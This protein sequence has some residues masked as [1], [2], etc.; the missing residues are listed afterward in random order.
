MGGENKGQLP[1]VVIGA[2]FSGLA[3]AAALADAGV[4]VHV[5]E[6]NAGIGGRARVRQSGGFT[7]DMGPSWYWMP[8][9]FER[10]YRR[11]GHTTSDFYDLVQLDPGFRM[12]FDE[13]EY[14][15]IP[16]D[17]EELCEL[18]ERTEIGAAGKLRRFIADAGYKYEVGVNNL[19]YKPARSIFEF[20]SIQM[21]RDV[22]KLQVF[23][24]FSSYIRRYFTHPRLLSLLEFPVLF[25][26]A[27]PKDTPALYSLMNYAGLRQGTWYPMGGFGRVVDAFAAIARERGAE[28]STSE[29]V[30]SLEVATG[31]IERV[32]TTSRSVKVGSVIGAADYHH[33]EQALLKPEYRTYSTQ[34]WEKKT[35]APS[36]LIYYIGTNKKIN[37]LQHHNLFFDADLNRH[38]E[39]IYRTKTWPENPL[40]YV[41]CPSK[42]DDSIAPDNCENIFILMPVAAGLDDA[43]NEKNSYL[44]IILDRLERFTRDKVR[45]HIVVC[46]Q[47]SVSDFITDYN[48]CKGNAYGL[49]NTLMQ[50]AV[51][52]PAIRSKKVRNLFFAGQLTVPGPGVPPSIISGQ[53]S[54]GEVLRYLRRI[55]Q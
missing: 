27:M 42:T 24:S 26:G 55:K 10:F 43:G 45:D 30:T 17:F 52:K 40:F 49:A 53:V 39:E 25:L 13:D 50:T 15:D 36:C 48:A 7:F 32:H 54:A 18:F 2:G 8:D 9:V 34:Y 16:A 28:I 22:T 35:F 31:T 37:R 19:V 6:K 14:W 51:L 5:V 41:C 11:F 33:V 4:E 12:I 21:L 46:E 29:A 3:A 44:Q 23:T 47:Y 1:A 38:A 20:I